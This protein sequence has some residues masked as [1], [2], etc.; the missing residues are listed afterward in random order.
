[1]PELHPHTRGVR[2]AEGIP[3]P[4]GSNRRTRSPAP[5]GKGKTQPLAYLR[6]KREYLV[7]AAGV[8]VQPR[9]PD[10]AGWLARRRR[11][12]N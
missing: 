4:A 1:M 5:G 8:D 11:C 6:D 12:L 2:R 7:D 10:N 9:P 3:A